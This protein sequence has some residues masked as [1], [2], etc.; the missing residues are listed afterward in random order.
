MLVTSPNGCHQVEELNITVLG[1]HWASIYSCMRQNINYWVEK[2]L[3]FFLK[4][5]CLGASIDLLWYICVYFKIYLFCF[6]RVLIMCFFK[7]FW[8]LLSWCIV[9]CLF[10]ILSVSFMEGFGASHSILY[11]F[12]SVLYFLSFLPLC[13]IH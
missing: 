1:R 6:L 12:I 8:N 13:F 3:S 5:F 4:M 2:L 10:L 11:P 7:K 9:Y